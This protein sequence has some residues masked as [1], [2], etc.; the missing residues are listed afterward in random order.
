MSCSFCPTEQKADINVRQTDYSYQID[1]R[2]VF[3][4]LVLR[5]AFCQGC[6]PVYHFGYLILFGTILTEQDIEDG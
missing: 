1:E 2:L 4:L 6:F 5:K 3:R